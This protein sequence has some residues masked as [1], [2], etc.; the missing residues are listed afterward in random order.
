MNYGQHGRTLLQELKRSEPGNNVDSNTACT[1]P[2]YNDLVVGNALQDLR[3]HC[4]ALQ[5]QVEATSSSDKPSIHVRPSLLLQNAAIQ[6]NKRCLLTYHVIRLRRIQEELYWKQ[7]TNENKTKSSQTNSNLC[8]SEQEFL[9]RYQ[10][11]VH[12]YTEAATQNTITDLRAFTSMPPQ[13]SDR[14]MIRVMVDLGPMVLDSGASAVLSKGSTHFL[15]Y[16]DVEE[17]IREGKVLVL[18]GEEDE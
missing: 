16:S 5:D 15:L 14:V 12:R 7:Q 10:D 1:I 2:S 9:T 3:L 17:A 4:Q 6:R 8:P 18:N 11:L 13:P